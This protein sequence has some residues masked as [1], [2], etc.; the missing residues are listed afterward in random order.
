LPAAAD[1]SSGHGNGCGPVVGSGGGEGDG[2]SGE[3]AIIGAA[4]NVPH[5]APA[6]APADGA[7]DLELESLMHAIDTAVIQV[8]SA[9]GPTMLIL[10]KNDQANLR[11]AR[12]AAAASRAAAGADGGGGISVRALLEEE[13][14]RGMHEP[15]ELPPPGSDVP[16]HERGALLYDPSAAIS[17]LWLRRSLRFTIVLMQ[18]LQEAH[19]RLED[20]LVLAEVLKPGE[21]PPMEAD[22]TAGC[23]QAAYDMTIRPFHSW[24]LRKTFDIVSTQ[25]PTLPEVIGMVGPGLGDAE[26]EGKVFD[27]MEFYLQH[28]QPV[29]DLLEQLMG[30]LKLED[31]RQV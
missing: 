31:V 4:L 7:P 19:Q 22:P 26:R 8:L 18:R 13:I 5:G 2:C 1:K 6:S 29:V 9:L 23:L 10:V 15:R 30:E 28:G 17:L 20:Q 24:L 21:A 25:C 16:A 12:D 3:G 11:K 27:E 14:A